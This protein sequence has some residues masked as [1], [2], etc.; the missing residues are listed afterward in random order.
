MRARDPRAA[1]A[2]GA[3]NRGI[4]GHERLLLYTTAIQTGLRSNELRQ[5][6]RGRLFLQSDQPYIVCKAG[7][8]KNKK[9]A[10][11][12]LLP[13]LAA[14]LKAHVATKAPQAPVFRMPYETDVVR[15]L[16]ADLADARRNWLEA[17]KNY[18]E[19]RLR[20]E[21]SDFLCESNHEGERLDFHSLR[22]TCGAWLSMTGAHPKVV[23]TVVRHQSITLTMDTYGHLFPG[24][25]AEAIA[26]VGQFFAEPESAAQATGTDGN[27]SD[28][29]QRTGRDSE[30]NEASQCD[31][32]KSKLGFVDN[33]NLLQVEDLCDTVRHGAVSIVSSGAG[34]RTPDTRIMIPLL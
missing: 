19:K 3:V 26:R 17:V 18:P 6:T 4:A 34:I 23:Q 15:L 32:S 33:L 8:A 7:T 9:E 10:K 21:Q 11:Q 5:L 31:S 2:A 27:T 22:H 29:V 1:T 14:Q 25:T 20:R 12:Q 13:E 16:R 28:Q 24:Q 30:R